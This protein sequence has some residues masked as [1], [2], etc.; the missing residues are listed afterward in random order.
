[1]A[2]EETNIGTVIID[3]YICK[4]HVCNDILVAYKQKK[5]LLSIEC[6]R[7]YYLIYFIVVELR[8]YSIKTI[9]IVLK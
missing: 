6:P 2:L 3:I 7:K 8:K 1:M 4:C 9:L 5:C